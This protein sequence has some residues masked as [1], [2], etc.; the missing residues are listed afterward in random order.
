[1]KDA[2][3]QETPSKRTPFLARFFTLFAGLAL[4]SA[5]LATTPAALDPTPHVALKTNLGEIVLE[6]DQQKAPKSVANFLQY[7]K[8]GYY[9]GTV[10]HRVIDGFMIQGGGFDKNMKQKATKAPI[11]NEAQNGLQNVTY[12]VAMARTGDPNSATAQF[13]INVNNNAALDYPGRDGFGYAVFGKVVSG[14]DVVDKI[15]AVPVADKG[16]FENV[17][18]TPVVI[19]S[20]TLLKT[21][22]AKL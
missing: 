12:S 7:V 10:F 13:F 22:P 17:P 20:A 14:M 21:A 19:E 2:T 3:M 6:L 4:G 8:S 9:K 1:M 11:K 18:V 16:P 5:A 15:K